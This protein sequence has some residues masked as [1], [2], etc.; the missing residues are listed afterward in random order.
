MVGIELDDKSHQQSSREARDEF[1]EKVYEAAKLP[2]VRF[3]VRQSY[4]TS[5]LNSVLH[6]YFDPNE[7]DTQTQ[8]AIAEVQS[9]SPL[10]PKCGGEMVL[11]TAKRGS[12]QGEQFWGCPNYPQCRGTRKYET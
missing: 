2:L 10:C 11:R 7:A 6:P 4:S 12:N 8:P 9:T 3:P 1:V 5:E